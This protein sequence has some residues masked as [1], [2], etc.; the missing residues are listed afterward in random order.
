MLLYKFENQRLMLNIFIRGVQISLKGK[1]NNFGKND[2]TTK[3]EIHI[4]FC[5]YVAINLPSAKY[6]IKTKI[7]ICVKY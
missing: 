4:C 7:T 5:K 1:I 2:K 6:F 3:T